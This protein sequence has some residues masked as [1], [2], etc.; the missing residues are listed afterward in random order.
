MQQFRPSLRTVRNA[1]V[2]S[3]LGS[4]FWAWAL[5]PTFS[6]GGSLPDCTSL[7]ALSIGSLA[8]GTALGVAYTSF[9]LALEKVLGRFI[10][11]EKRLEPENNALGLSG[12]LFLVQAIIVGAI[13]LAGALP[14]NWP[15]WLGIWGAV[16]T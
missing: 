15:W 9:T 11:E 2:A 4:V 8:Y 14:S 12:L 10:P 1:V 6:R 5:W 16:L 13:A 3:L 7:V